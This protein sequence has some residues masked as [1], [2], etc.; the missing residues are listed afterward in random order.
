MEFHSEIMRVCVRVVSK[1][2]ASKPC[3]GTQVTKWNKSVLA[4]R[5]GHNNRKRQKQKRKEKR[6]VIF[7]M[8]HC[9][10]R[11][12][13]TGKRGTHKSVCDPVTAL[14]LNQCHERGNCC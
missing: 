5:V 8:F 2:I 7:I 4:A 9:V 14:Q 13:L 3:P 1:E 6:E 11:R 12:R 10:C